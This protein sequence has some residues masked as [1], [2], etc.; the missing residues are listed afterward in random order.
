MAPKTPL[1]AKTLAALGTPRLCELL[2]E[3]GERDAAIKRR[4]RL[5]LASLR[6]ADDIIREISKRLKTIARSRSFVEWHQ[7]KPLVQDLDMQRRAIA[8]PAANADPAAALELMWEF[9]GLANSI[10]ARCDD[11]NGV[12]GEVFGNALD[13]VGAIAGA[14]KASPKPLADRIFNALTDNGYGQYDGLI[15]IFSPHL[16]Q[17]GLEHLK[18][19]FLK[20]AKTPVAKPPLDQRKKIGWGPGG[21]IY[22][23]ELTRQ[24]QDVTISLAL[25]QIADAQGDVDAFIAQQSEKARGVPSVASGIADRLLAVGRAQEALSALD[26]IDGRWA[27]RTPF[28]WEATRIDALEALGRNQEAQ[29]FRW[30]CFQRSFNANHLRAYLKRLPDFDDIEAEERALSFVQDSPDHHAVLEFLVF[31]PALEQAAKLVFRHAD[32]WNGDLYELLSPAAEALGEKQPLAATILLRSMIDF[33][34]VNGRSKRY[35]HA[36]R[37]LTECANLAAAIGDF[38]SL[39]G[40]EPYI[41]GLKAQHG[42]KSGFWGLLS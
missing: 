23:D 25:Q 4:L 30:A 28:E 6:S 1:N 33:T 8:G 39:P 32:A 14:A 36:A 2:M 41:A 22:E 31:W 29:A 15:E 37:H 24:H 26:A 38:G 5:E 7:L 34:L 35:R 11:S 13:D 27:N 12:I 3:F 19:R 9:L 40:H 16:G 18:A 42:R 10:F 17:E 20:L 21:P